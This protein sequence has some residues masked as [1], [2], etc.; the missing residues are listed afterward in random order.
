MEYL[1]IRVSTL[2]GDQPIDFDAY[3]KINEKHILYLRKGDSFEGDRLKRLKAKNLKKMFIVPENE[4]DYRTYLT[5][6]I[7]MAFDKGA[8]KSYQ[9]RGEIIQGRQQS[10]GE[11]VME[12]PD[13]EKSYTEAKESSGRFIEYLTGE[14]PHS[15]NSILNIE[16]IDQNVAHHGVTVSTL[17]VALAKSLGITDAKKLQLLS[18]GAMLHDIEHFYSGIFIARPLKDFTAD[19]LRLYK[20]HPSTGAAIAQGKKHFDTTVINIIAQH[21]EYID[22]KGFPNGLVEAKMDPLSII[23]ASANSYDRLMTFE[24]V[25]KKDLA[26]TLLVSSVGKYPLNHIQSLATIISN[27]DKK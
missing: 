24:K 14:D 12:N 22:G 6:N 15:V 8:G 1:P 23:V 27:S 3:I 19:E 26:K 16:N 5:R 20:N 13:D 7:D 4:T 25:P 21:E 11:A 10:L 17:S 2:R 9:V 18:L